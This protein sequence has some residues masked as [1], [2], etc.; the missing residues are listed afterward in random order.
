MRGALPVSDTAARAARGAATLNRAVAPPP[1]A[2]APR[3]A[4][5]LVA[6]RAAVD[7]AQVLADVRSIIAEQVR[8]VCC[9]PNCTRALDWQLS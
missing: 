9:Q 6:C 7:K 5:R 2:P 8:L 3:L 1:Q 4:P